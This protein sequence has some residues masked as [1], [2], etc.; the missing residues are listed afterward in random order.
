MQSH[1]RR[2]KPISN[3]IRP[4]RILEYVVET[5][6]LIASAGVCAIRPLDTMKVRGIALCHNATAQPHL[7]ASLAADLPSF[8]LK[9]VPGEGLPQAPAVPLVPVYLFY[10]RTST[11][12]PV[13]YS[14]SLR[15][16]ARI[17]ACKS[18]TYSLTSRLEP[19]LGQAR[20]LP[21]SALLPASM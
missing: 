1:H 8:A 14:Q 7:S 15:S 5:Q 12:P 9:F 17:Y 4:V 18:D 11:C 13:L 10:L 20:R 16:C 6:S 2:P 3:N 21:S 19:L